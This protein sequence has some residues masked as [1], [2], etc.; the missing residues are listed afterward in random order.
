MCRRDAHPDPCETVEPAHRHGTGLPGW[1]RTWFAVPE[2]FPRRD[3]PKLDR[4]AVCVHMPADD[5]ELP[6]DGRASFICALTV[7]RRQIERLV[8]YREPDVQLPGHHSEEGPG[9]MVRHIAQHQP[10]V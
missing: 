9:P 8:S 5:D 1:R 2:P 3:V 6:R 7:S 10:D 4:P